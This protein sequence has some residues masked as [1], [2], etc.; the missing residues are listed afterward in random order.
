MKI[1]E[2][3]KHSFDKVTLFVFIISL[4]VFGGFAYFGIETDI[5]AHADVITGIAHNNLSLPPN[6]LYYVVIYLFSFFRTDTKSVYLASIFVLAFS[7]TLKYIITKII[8]KHFLINKN[9]DL[10]YSLYSVLL[11]FIFSLPLIM[12]LGG[13]YYLGNIPPNVW[14]NSTV[15]F[16]MP[17]SLLLFWQSYQQ[18]Q[19]PRKNRNFLLLCLI[20]LNI[21]IKPSFFF[22]FSISYPLFIIKIFGWKKQ[23]LLKL[24]PV[25]IGCFILAIQYIAIYVY[26]IGSLQGGDSTVKIRLFTIW[27]NYSPNIPI[28]LLGS[29]C[30]PLVCTLFYWKDIFKNLLVIYASFQYLIAII[31]FAVFVETGPR[32][33]HANF[34]WQCIV[35]SYILYLVI[36]IFFIEK[37][38]LNKMDK[39]ISYAGSIMKMTLKNRLILITLLLHFISGIV[40]IVRIFVTKSYS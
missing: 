8:I 26:Q 33:F 32:E 23:A 19:D 24:I 20:I 29:L 31:I 21:I 3:T 18:I 10:F 14:H 30:F 37:L 38:E 2:F 16:L 5:P 1:Q 15:I 11:T 6:F 40:Y 39:H 34:V 35:S 7:V 12:L 22:V 25:F 13:N 27:S 36:S 9:L 17:F 4:I 28:S